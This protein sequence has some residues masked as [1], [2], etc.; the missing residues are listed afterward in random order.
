VQLPDPRSCAC[1]HRLDELLFAA[2]CGVSS[3]A[4]T[5]VSV[6]DWA[7][8][9]LNWLRRYLPFANGVASHDTFGRV[10]SLLDPNQFEACFVRWMQQLIPALAGD[11]IAIDGKSLRRSYDEGT[12][13]CAAP[14]SSRQRCA[15]IEASRIAVTGCWT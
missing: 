13:R 4:D 2:L 10:F 7:E 8:L 11:L 3:G 6:T 12:Q 5:W 1:A 9:Q 14:N 15:R